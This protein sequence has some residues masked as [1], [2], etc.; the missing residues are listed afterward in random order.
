MKPFRVKTANGIVEMTEEVP[1]QVGFHGTQNISVL[2]DSPAALSLGELCVQHGYTFIWSANEK[3]PIFR[4]QNGKSIPVRTIK[5]VPYFSE[6]DMNQ[7]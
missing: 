6:E 4:D 1:T 2:K 3:V 7:E 5:N